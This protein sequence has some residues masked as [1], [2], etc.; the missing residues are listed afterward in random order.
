MRISDWSSDVCSSDLLNLLRGLGSS[1]GAAILLSL[2]TRNIHVNRSTLVEHVSPFNE[3]LRDPGLGL[4]W[5]LEVPSGLASLDAQ[6]MHQATM[7]AYQN[8]FLVMMAVPLLGIP[9]TLLLR[10]RRR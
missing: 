9:L 10:R 5:A 3:L 2:L 1:L 8:D 7:I 6:V 4:R